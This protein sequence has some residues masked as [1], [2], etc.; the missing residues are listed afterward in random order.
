MLLENV[1]KYARENQKEAKAVLHKLIV[2][3]L[4]LSK[5]K[6]YGTHVWL[7][8]KRLDEIKSILEGE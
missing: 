6:H 3:G 1:A 8:T 4:I 7:N 2:Q 5:Q